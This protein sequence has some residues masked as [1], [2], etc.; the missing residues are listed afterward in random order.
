MVIKKTY[1][2]VYGIIIKN[3][4]IY[5]RNMLFTRMTRNVSNHVPIVWKYTKAFL[6]SWINPIQCNK[7]LGNFT[8]KG[9]WT[10]VK[11]P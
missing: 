4:P 8:N 7:K 10:L 2:G 11:M 1:I 3:K 5:K 9:T 6:R